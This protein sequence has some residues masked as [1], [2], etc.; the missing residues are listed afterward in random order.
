MELSQLWSLSTGS[1]C[2]SGGVLKRNSLCLL[3][4]ASAVSPSARRPYNSR[5]SCS[6]NAE[7]A[8]RKQ[9]NYYFTNARSIASSATNQVKGCKQL[10]AAKTGHKTKLTKQEHEHTQDHTQEH[11]AAGAAEAEE[12]TGTGAD[13]AG[14]APA[15]TTGQAG[16]QPQ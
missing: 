4:N 15:Q 1:P 7:A 8:S 16:K 9:Q 14:E 13:T 12:K 5:Q 11:A 2:L 6:V 10:E 3:A